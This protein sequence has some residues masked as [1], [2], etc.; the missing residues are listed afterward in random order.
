MGTIRGMFMVA[1]LLVVGANLISPVNTAV[2]VM[3]TP[4]YS[5]SV[6]SLSALLPLA[7]VLRLLMSSFEGI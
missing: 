3:A 7:L 6:V 1:L 5:A 4:T 2:S